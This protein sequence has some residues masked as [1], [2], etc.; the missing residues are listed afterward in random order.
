MYQ[1]YKDKAIDVISRN[2]Y[3]LAD[4]IIGIGF[5]I[6]D[7]IA[8][9]IGIA[10][11]SA[12]RIKAGI[13]YCLN[14]AANN[15]NVYLPME[16][17]VRKVSELL[18]ISPEPISNEMTGM[19]IA[20]YI[21]IDRTPEYENVYL[22]YFYYAESYVARKLIELADM[23]LDNTGLYDD[24]I[25]ALAYSQGIT[26]AKEQRL[27]IIEA[28]SNGVLVITGGPGT[29]KTTIINAIIQL[30]EAEGMEVTLAAPTGRAAK[31][32]EEATGHNAQTIHRLLGVTFLNEDSNR[33]TF[34]KN[35]EEPIETDILII[36]ES[37]MI[38]IMLM[39]A[40]L[41]AVAI[42]T[43]VIIVGDSNQLPS[44]GAGNVLKDIITSGEIKVVQLTEIFRQAQK[45][46]I[47]INAHKINKG[48][49]P[50]LS[51]NGSDFFFMKRYNQNEICS[52]LVSLVTTRL[53]KYLNCKPTDI[54]V[55]T[56]MRKQGLGVASVNAILQQAI[57]PPA[58]NKAEKVMKNMTFREGD[59][60]MQ[61]KNDYEMEWK[62]IRNNIVTDKGTGIYNGDEGFITYIDNDSKF[63]EVVF[64]ENKVVHY[65]FA[66]LDKLEL[67]YAVT[68]HKSQG[69]E[70]RAV[71]LPLLNGPEM[72]MTRNLLYTGLTRA[73]NLAVIVGSPET[74]YNM[75]DNNREIE[76][77][78]T[79]S[80]KIKEFAKL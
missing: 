54:Q 75:V 30:S 74:V 70:Y 43:R 3:S 42:G 57:N 24:K 55:L 32:M 46:D 60:V 33:Q 38:D 27:A 76:R 47:I 12:F 14:A 28:M 50:N 36:D 59:K 10:P 56:P 29:G 63:M 61:I 69:S 2:P 8:A 58:P 65:D 66:Q 11:D 48:E 71:I 18:N 45:S 26:F 17:L 73:K 4:D 53:P 52:L 20:N 9:K 6:A 31:R 80:K 34:C 51:K 79:L 77:F 19:H 7:G 41:K 21:W 25:D 15:G 72:L 78:T 62:L 68:I 35:E 1:K 64:D 44:V 49:H 40:L 37:S 67:S 22:N 5:K 39:Q 16:M 23:E 13:R